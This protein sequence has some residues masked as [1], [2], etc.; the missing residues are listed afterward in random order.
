M[1]HVMVND[2]QWI[3]DDDAEQWWW[4]RNCYFDEKREH[5]LATIST[6][7]VKTLNNFLA[8]FRLM[9]VS[10]NQVQRQLSLRNICFL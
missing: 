7:I 2:G 8:S 9:I 1:F 10:F 4:P 5:G 6:R 3:Y